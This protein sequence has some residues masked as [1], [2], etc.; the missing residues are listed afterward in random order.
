M[1]KS[2]GFV[3]SDTFH[4][5]DAPV[6]VGTTHETTPEGAGTPT[7]WMGYTNQFFGSMMYLAGEPGAVWQGKFYAA[8][9]EE[10]PK[11]RTF[12]TGIQIEGLTLKANSAKKIDF[13]LFAGPK[14]R[15]LFTNEKHPQFK[16]SY[17]ELNYLSTINLKVCF[18]AFSWLSLAMMW[19]L[20]KLSVVAL[21][22]YGVA[23]FMLV[24]LVR[25]ALHPLAKKSQVSMMKMQKLAPQIQKLKEKYKDD[26]ERLNKEMMQFYKEQ[27]T[28][29]LLGCL[30]MLLQMPIWIALWTSV[31]ASVELRHAA[32][33]P[34]W[35]IDLAA[36]DRLF[37][38]GTPVPFIGTDLNLL[39]ILLAVA[40]FLQTKLNPQM[41]QVAATE[42]QQQQQKMMRYMMPAMMLLIFYAMPSGLTLYIMAS[43]SAG[44]AEQYV[45]RRH[46]RAK[47]AT[48]AAKETTVAVPGKPPR[49]A[50]PKKPKGPTWIKRG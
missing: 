7:L 37:S 41:G 18:C 30:P 42:Q 28:T 3:P 31:Q 39:P 9:A 36:P 44:V 8:A 19:L 48:A 24:V 34:V 4:D 14:K 6:V 17:K 43:T 50:R 16:P 20:Q 38:W 21:G 47:E 10:S 33:L 46:I 25:I 1:G 49:K 32:F 2:E 26:K 15:D 13:E 22:N 12:L 23:I 45:I 27:G 29:P 40:M 35:I 11:T 5:I